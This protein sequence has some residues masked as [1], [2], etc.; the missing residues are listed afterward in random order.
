MNA[1]QIA[2]LVLRDERPAEGRTKK[3]DLTPTRVLK[4]HALCQR[5]HVALD[6]V[7]ALLPSDVQ[8]RIKAGGR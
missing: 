8:D 2:D 5:Q 3:L 6:E 7:L 1:Q 4:L